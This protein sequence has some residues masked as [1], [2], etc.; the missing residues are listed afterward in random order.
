MGAS[1]LLRCAL[2]DNLLYVAIVPASGTSVPN[3]NFLDRLFLEIWG[4][5]QNKKVGVPDFPRCPL[6]EEFL[7]RALVCVN[8]Y[9]CAKF[10]FTSSR[11]PIADTFLYRALV[12]VNAYKCAK[13]QLGNFQDGKI[14][15]CKIKAIKHLRA[16]TL[17]NLESWNLVRW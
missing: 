2:R 4:W 1:D 13:F 6:A 17:I 11:R 10:Q 9:K 14:Y 12:R 5:S 8:A 7:Y 3:F 15:E 16:L